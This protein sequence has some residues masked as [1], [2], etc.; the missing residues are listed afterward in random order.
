[1]HSLLCLPSFPKL[2]RIR[3][4]ISMRYMSADG[5]QFVDFAEPLNIITCSHPGRR[6]TVRSADRARNKASFSPL[7]H[8]VRSISS[9]MTWQ[10]TGLAF[11]ACSCIRIVLLLAS[12][13]SID[14]QGIF[15]GRV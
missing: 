7:A 13:A 1:M 9:R 15:G 6:P 2:A 14:E 4:S 8:N 10:V 11:N 12:Q 3:L 5:V